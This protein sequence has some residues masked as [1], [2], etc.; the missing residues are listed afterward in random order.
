M[1][2]GEEK[3][4][5]SSYGEENTLLEVRVYSIEPSSMTF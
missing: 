3:K 4:E 2:E 5:G 1:V